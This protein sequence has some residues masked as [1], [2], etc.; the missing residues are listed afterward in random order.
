MPRAQI[1]PS[2]EALGRGADGTTLAEHLSDCYLLAGRYADAAK[3]L[4]AKAKEI[5]LGRW[6]EPDDIGQMAVYL[7]SPAGD[8]ITGSIFV[9]DGGS[10]LAGRT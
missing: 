5:P 8:W 3:A 10:W 1:G 7:A 2:D 9:V 4:E 6:G